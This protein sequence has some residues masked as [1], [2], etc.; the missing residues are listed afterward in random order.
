MINVYSDITQTALKY[1]KDTEANIHNILVMAGNFNIR[2]S[3][4]DLSFNFHSIHS[5][6]ITNI[7]SG[8]Q[9]EVHI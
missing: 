2:D 3:S 5:D 7:V 9:Y 6:I 8:V 1:L 4:W